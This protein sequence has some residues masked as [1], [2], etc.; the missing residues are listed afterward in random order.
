MKPNVKVQSPVSD[1]ERAIAEMDAQMKLADRIA[2]GVL[3]LLLVVIA[4]V[5]TWPEWWGRL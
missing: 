5:V 1:M 3:A 2:M 4:S